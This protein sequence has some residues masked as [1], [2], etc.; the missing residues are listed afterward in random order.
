MQ[1]TDHS[2]SELFA[3]LGLPD[4]EADIQAFAAAHRTLPGDALL[5]EAPFWTE[6]QARFLREEI[7][8]DAAWAPAVDQ[9]N[10]MLHKP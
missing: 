3:Q 1:L 2:V 5:H 8:N 4:G 6:S 9:L 7:R 10:L